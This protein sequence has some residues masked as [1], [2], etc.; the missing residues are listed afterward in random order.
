MSEED[1]TA[2][3]ESIVDDTPSEH[4]SEP[5]A[6]ERSESI[7][8]VTTWLNDFHLGSDMAP[9]P[10]VNIPTGESSTIKINPPQEFNG[11]KGTLE[12]FRMQCLLA[13]EMSGSKLPT[14]RKKVLY[15]V[16]FLRGAAYDWVHPHFKDF[17]QHSESKQKEYTKTLFKDYASL[18][19]EMEEVFDNGDEALEADR[20]IRAL[21][22]RTS[23]AH[24]R[25]EFQILAAK[26]DW[27]D[28]ALASQFYRGLK[29]GVRREITLHH[30][31]PSVLKDLAE[32]A[33][34]IDQRMFELQLEKRGDYA[35]HGANRKSKRDVPEWKDNYYGLQKMQL[36]ATQ[37]KPGSGKNKKQK[38]RNPQA[39]KGTKDKSKVECYACH[40]KGHYSNECKAR[41]Q[42]HELQESGQSKR[43]QFNATKGKK[44][45]ASTVE[46]ARKADDSDD[47]T[48]VE[49]FRATTG[50][51]SYD[52]NGA[53]I[54]KHTQDNHA[55]E[56]WTAC[57]DDYC[58]IHMSDKQGSGYWPAKVTR[59]VCRTM[60]QPGRTVRYPA[61]YPPQQDSTSEEEEETSSE[62]E[63]EVSEVESN[64][65]PEEV[66]TIDFTRTADANDVIHRVLA[67]VWESKN[68]IFPWNADGD[69]QLVN[70]S[71]FWIM[72]GKLRAILWHM[73]HEKHSVDHL[74]IVHEFPPLG[75]RFTDRGGYFTPAD[76]C[77]TRSLRTRV[78]ELKRAYMSEVTDQ[79]KRIPSQNKAVMYAEDRP[80]PLLPLEYGQEPLAVRKRPQVPRA[81]D[82][83]GVYAPHVPRSLVGPRSDGQ[84]TSGTTPAANGHF[85]NPTGLNMY[86]SET[87][88]QPRDA[89]N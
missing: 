14:D 12:R 4:G 32:L 50:R 17:L 2:S 10:S 3:S 81:G 26:L 70:D 79:A 72:I 13:I 44:N 9:T 89:G 59:S 30:E 56:S 35:S 66:G 63:G 52:L 21:R 80:R 27:N 23:A 83:T 22:Q 48:R 55:M 68:L 24:Y 71:E 40:Q 64:G 77:I 29:E 47:E 1:S 39:T 67:L 57:Y 60:G 65:T 88:I 38:G 8:I 31:R 42:R 16:S 78:M 74:K 37:G 43:Q 61:G 73:P 53:N 54:A 82:A 11:A 15:I 5:T 62:E 34:K 6:E 33:I 51:G 36:D 69:E 25:A 49:S 46:D 86:W 85:V 18:F 76:V 58:A 20:D 87:P 41:K 75:S 84:I 19:D 7:P 28:D 45:K